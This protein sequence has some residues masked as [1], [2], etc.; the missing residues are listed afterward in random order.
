VTERG[1]R[2]QWCPGRNRPHRRW[3]RRWGALVAIRL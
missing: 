3:L 1:S 2:R